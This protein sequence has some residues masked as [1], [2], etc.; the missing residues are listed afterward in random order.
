MKRVKLKKKKQ[1]A[2]LDKRIFQKW[3]V[4]IY[5]IYMFQVKVGVTNANV[6]QIS[7]DCQITEIRER[8]FLRNSHTLFSILQL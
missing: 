1:D 6:E 4:Y 3:I 5:I 7:S 8:S 2:E